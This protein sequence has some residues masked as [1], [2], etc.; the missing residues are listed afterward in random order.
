MPSIGQGT[1]T[2]FFD[3]AGVAA[4]Y[5]QDRNGNGRSN[6]QV[7]FDIQE[8]WANPDS[9]QLI[10]AGGD[11]KYGQVGPMNSTDPYDAGLYPTGTRYDTSSSEADDDN[12]TNFS[13]KARLGDD[14]P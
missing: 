9:F 13:N 3:G 11:G 5:W 2:L 7:D 8:T 1:A 4:P 6:L 10:A 12:V 14:K